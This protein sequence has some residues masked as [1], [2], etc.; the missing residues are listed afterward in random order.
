MNRLHYLLILLTITV[1]FQSFAQSFEWSNQFSG[2]FSVEAL[3]SAIDEDGHVYTTGNFRGTVNFNM[4]APGFT[5]NSNSGSGDIFVCKHN[6]EGSL[7]WLAVMGSAADDSGTDIAVDNEGNILIT[8]YFRSTVDFNPGPDTF[9]VSSNGSED[10][11]V[12]NLNS[13]G[14]FLWAKNFGGA[15]NEI[16]AALAIDEENNIYITGS[17]IGSS[18]FDPSSSEYILDSEGQED[19]FLLK[20]D[21]SASFLWAN[22]YGGIENDRP[23]VVACEG[24]AIYVGGTFRSFVDFSP[25]AE[26]SELTSLGAEDG[27]ILR[28]DDSGNFAW[29]NALH[30]T[31]VCRIRSLDVNTSGTIKVIGEFNTTLNIEISGLNE[32]T[33]TS[34]GSDAFIAEITASGQW[35]S[36]QIMA[37]TGNDKG[38]A[39]E[40]QDDGSVYFVATFDST[41][42]VPSGQAILHL[43][44]S[45]VSGAVIGKYSVDHELMWYRQAS[46]TGIVSPY[47]IAVGMNNELITSGSF[48]GELA[49]EQGAFVYNSAGS[50]DGFI[51]KYSDC[52]NNSYSVQNL[53]VCHFFDLPSGSQQYDESGSYVDVIPNSAGCDSVITFNLEILEGPTAFLNL[54]SCDGIESPSGDEVWTESGHYIDFVPSGTGCDTLYTVDLHIFGS[55]DDCNVANFEWANG[56]EGS[57]TV[58]SEDVAVDN[59]G[60]SY[61]CGHFGG[62][63]DTDPNDTEPPHQTMGTND[64]FI[65][66]FNPEG[67][68]LW[69]KFIGGASIDEAFSIDLDFNNNVYVTG[70]FNQTVDFDPGFGVFNMDASNGKGFLLRLDTHGEFIWA[71]Q[72]GSSSTMFPTAMDVKANEALYIAG[73]FAGTGDFDPG[74]E[75]VELSPLGGLDLFFMKLDLG[76]NLMWAQRRGGSQSDYAHG[77]A[78]D[79]YGNVYATGSYYGSIDFNP[80]ASG[81]N[82]TS[83]GFFDNSD[84]Y[85]YK[86]TS[87]GDYVW[88]RDFGGEYTDRGQDIT[89]DGIGNVYVTGYFS[90]NMTIETVFG[91]E[92]LSHSTSSNDGF[93]LKLYSE[94]LAWWDDDDDEGYVQWVD[95]F[96]SGS[97]NREGYGVATDVAGNVY[98]TGVSDGNIS[99]V[100][101][102]PE[103]SFIDQYY[104]PSPGSEQGNAVAT[105]WQGNVYL[106]GFHRETTDFVDGSPEYE[107]TALNNADGFLVKLKNCSDNTYELVE[108]EVCEEFTFNDGETEHV[109]TSTGVY[110]VPGM[111]PDG[112]GHLTTFELSF[113]YGPT[114]SD[115]ISVC[116]SFESPSGNDTWIQSG[117]YV[118][119]V[120][121]PAGDCDSIVTIYLDVINPP[122][123]KHVFTCS[124]YTSPFSG[125]SYSPGNF[126]EYFDADSCDDA[127]YL[128]VHENAP[129]TAN[130]ESLEQEWVEYGRNSKPSSGGNSEIWASAYDEEG[131]II[132]VGHYTQKVVL[133]T[134]ANGITFNSNS[135]YREPL[136]MKHDSNGNLMWAKR[137]DTQ[138]T[139]VISYSDINTATAVASDHL[140]NT[141]VVGNFEQTIDVTP[142]GSPTILTA[143]SSSES[144]VFI[145]KY[146]ASGNLLMSGVLRGEGEAY[147]NDI[148]FDSNGNFVL[149]GSYEG[150]IDFDLGPEAYNPS[151]S[152]Y[153]NTFVAKYTNTGELL[154]AKKLVGNR[155]HGHAVTIGQNNEVYV[156][157]KYRN[158]VDFNP[159]TGEHELTVNTYFNMYVLRLFSNGNFS[160]VREAESESVLSQINR[161]ESTP[162]GGLYCVGTFE[163]EYVDFNTSETF[164]WI[165]AEGPSDAFIWKLNA[166]TGNST[167]VHQV[168][169]P[170]IDRGKSIAIGENGEIYVAGEFTNTVNFNPDGEELILNGHPEYQNA[171][172]LEM[173]SAGEFINVKQ[174]GGQSSNNDLNVA[175]LTIHNSKASLAGTAFPGSSLSMGS[176]QVL[177]NQNSHHHFYVTQLSA[178]SFE[179]YSSVEVSVCDS[180]V[181]PSGSFVWNTSGE[182]T[183]AIPNMNGCDSVITTNLTI[184]GFSDTL[185][186]DACNSYTWSHNNITYENS[187]H[188]TENYTNLNGCDSTYVLALTINETRYSEQEITTC[189]SLMSPSG[190][191]VWYSSGSYLD[192]IPTIAGCDSILT[193]NLT[194]Q[195]STS[196]EQSATACESYTSPS[197][198]Y[199]WTSSG[200][201]TD[202]IPNAIGCDSILTINLEILNG[203]LDS[204]NLVACNSYTWPENNQTYNNSG[205]YEEVYTAVNG[206]DSVIQIDLEIVDI[207]TS[208]TQEGATLY[209]NESGANYQWIDCENNLQPIPGE[210]TQLF[211][212]T[213]N[214]IYAVEISVGEC[215]D[216]SNCVA[217][218]NVGVSEE[219]MDGIMVYPN[220]TNGLVNIMNSDPVKAIDGLVLNALGQEVSEFRIVEG[221]EHFQ[222]NIEGSRGVY[223]IELWT[224]EG[225]KGVVRIVKM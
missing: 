195:N 95:D 24:N 144:N 185:S 51:Q 79:N 170:E 75:V 112:C 131:G 65:A 127:I 53:E 207:D 130:C 191:S 138:G 178:C 206:C 20:L 212:P 37:S 152:G 99:M 56:F 139:N 29:V 106:T 22:R 114:R 4:D 158:T 6:S 184:L 216:T 154:W 180:L 52:S 59:D 96:G 166:T 87:D 181:S 189:D 140:G 218:M 12:L 225:K 224:S 205:V 204:E 168:S 72:F 221:H 69:T 215:T 8:G 33:T 55:P 182:Y 208:L 196:A 44:P 115:S 179:T 13:D 136:I 94:A 68:Q 45:G 82:L 1:S 60:N 61:V 201:Y 74:P 183:D 176:T 211:S 132:S 120:N 58:L 186:L 80:G 194:V 67:K 40:L 110:S 173:N 163:G 9:S 142:E 18:D 121:N 217:I 43:T 174:M 97:S 32:T 165:S 2:T 202:I 107:L 169:G 172:L 76:G 222:F 126:M 15:A 23:T 123:D 10:G 109:W 149:T 198:E 122:M 175:D 7:L 209:A 192:T 38:M 54:F 83:A 151:T 164:A 128:N 3:S 167:W 125:T 50:N 134:G 35:E 86:F 129:T 16:P 17:F 187:G 62:N 11:F 66:K 160:W 41:I 199:I 203:Y 124:E 210:T 157:G 103:G 63:I 200:T 100:S 104:L 27:F 148:A 214:G 155:N 88:A 161:I 213:E 5:E 73:Y 102:T 101:R 30:D 135:G 162:D 71:K 197:G 116:N 48:Q 47:S 146:S 91:D 108:E 105:D 14:E 90:G 49:F 57:F 34:G 190:N 25:G 64:I 171:F 85:V 84:I 111:N 147:I 31:D 42:S 98:Y 36:A 223:F 117:T 39:I 133:T 113:N 220:P 92:T 150:Y 156:A 145:C 141:I 21:E 81:G 46:S 159:G 28:T 89:T 119:I 77:I 19:I 143:H 153:Q 93:I 26:N 118:D 137:Y 177:E 219:R 70:S 193:I 188:Y 78:A